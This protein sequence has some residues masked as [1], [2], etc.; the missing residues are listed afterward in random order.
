M[1]DP[2]QTNTLNEIAVWLL[3]AYGGRLVELRLTLLAHPDRRLLGV[4]PHAV[5]GWSGRRGGPINLPERETWQTLPSWSSPGSVD[6]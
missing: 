6:G 4:V 2:T 5:R 1:L 3:A